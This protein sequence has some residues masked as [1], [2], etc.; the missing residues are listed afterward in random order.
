MA[1]TILSEASLLDG[2]NA[3]RRATLVIEGERIVEITDGPVA[4]RPGDRRVELAGR[5]V[6]PGMV[7]GHYH[8]TYKELGSTFTPFGLDAPPPLQA[9]RAAANLRL[10]LE[11]GFTG[12]ISAGAPFAIDAAMKLAISEG[13][14]IGPRLMA[15][16]RDVSTT[17]HSNDKTF[18]TYWGITAKGG[19][20]LADG[21]EGFRRAVREEIKEGAEIIKI[22]A[23]G[24]HGVQAPASEWAVSR[25]ELSMAIRT[26]AER[27]VF[28]RAHL[29][30]RDAIL[31]SIEQGMHII[32][33]GDEFDDA[34][35]EACLRHGAFLAP[36]LLFPKVMLQIAAGS[37]F[38]EGMRAGLE[39]MS[40]ILPRAHAAGVKIILGDDY[41]AAGFPHGRY[42]EELAL[43]V[44]DVGMAPLDV[45]RWATKNGAEA[46]NLGEETGT[47]KVGKLADLLVI[48][49]DP[50]ADIC[51]LQDRSRLLAVFKGGAAIK[52]ELDGLAST[53]GASPAF[54]AA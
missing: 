3:P 54:T 38:A 44:N 40:A 32:D 23:T 49:G 1:R 36:S 53:A 34:C 5:T 8:A 46:M 29:A 48:D 51:V 35:I 31:F 28:V 17:G 2:E 12:V 22:F 41:G 26:A 42:A 9:V 45:I 25:E 19:V 13:T 33:H 10:A 24:G 30:N 43:Y 52:D 4:P 27:G 7:L 14:I 11:S 39:S 18:P 37:S 50:I 6:M 15:C 16:S 20:N 47:L 21:P